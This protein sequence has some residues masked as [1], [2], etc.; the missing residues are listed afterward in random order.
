[1]NILPL[2]CDVIDDMH[3]EEIAKHIRKEMLETHR[4]Q[5]VSLELIVEELQLKR[6]TSY[7]PLYQ[8]AFTFH[9]PIQL[10]LMYL[11]HTSFQNNSP[12]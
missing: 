5:E 7:N 8:V 6:D 2:H 12:Q 3:F 10:F 11:F 1:M 9:P 4:N